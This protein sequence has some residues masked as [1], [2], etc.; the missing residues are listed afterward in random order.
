MNFK[1]PLILGCLCVS[2]MVGHSY[3]QQP[4]AS[5]APAK[6]RTVSRIFWQD[7]SSDKIRWSNVQKGAD[8]QIEAADIAGFPKLDPDQTDFVQMEEIDGIV[9]TG[10]HDHEDGAVKSG[11]VALDA[12]VEKEAHGDHFHWHYSK[13]PTVKAMKL[14]KDQGNP[15]HVYTYGNR[16]YLANDKKNGFTMVD[17]AALTSGKAADRFFE[18]G[19]GH[20][21]LAAVD[22]RVG[23]STWIDRDGDNKGRV[24]VVPL[25]S[26]S[27]S[28][29][30]F[31]L[32]S[33]GIHGATTNSGKVFFAPSDGICWVDADM[34]LAR[35]NSSATVAHLSLGKSADDKP[36]RTG[37]FANHMQW[38][39][40]VTGSGA[41]ASF[42]MID[43]KSPK[44]SVVK[45][46]LKLDASATVTTPVPVKSPNGKHFALVFQESKDGSAKEKLIVLNLDS[47][48][49]GS[50]GDVSLAQTVEVGASQIEGHGG[51]HELAITPSRRFAFVTN[52]GD[53]TIWVLSLT[54]LSVQA[55]LKV[56]GSPTRIVAVGG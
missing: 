40:C 6:P 30:S 13:A 37:A 11:W 49:D 10:I 2:S 32:P 27:G 50:L 26:G 25:V 36:L 39:L 47:N 19:G 15:A 12:G 46:P 18:G 31:Q 9:L 44:P 22:N 43:A 17:A 4:N 48:S 34:S 29:Y 53:G 3:A 45:H 7:S 56:N 54:D 42:C 8:W 55:K 16:F 33:G 51:H 35:K 28:A 23:Y 14:D 38:V 20:I 21:T 41:D 52:P 24:D 1:R 5:A